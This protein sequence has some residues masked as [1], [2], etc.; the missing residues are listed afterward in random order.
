MAHQQVDHVHRQAQIVIQARQD[1]Q[2]GGF[3]LFAQ[4]FLR[5]GHQHPEAGVVFQQVRQLL[6]RVGAALVG[7]FRDTAVRRPLQ[8]PHV[9]QC[10]FRR[11]APQQAPVEPL[12]QRLRRDR[13]V[14]PLEQQVQQRR[15]AA[16]GVHQRVHLGGGEHHALF[17]SPCD[18][19]CH[20]GLLLS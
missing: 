16:A 20:G 7:R 10:G 14:Q 12:G 6:G 4:L 18:I 3:Q 13:A 1:L 15:V 5:L 8:Q 11:V 17:L 19:A 9:L 2:V